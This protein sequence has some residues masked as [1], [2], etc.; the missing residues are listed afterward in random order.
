LPQAGTRITF[1]DDGV[2][3]QVSEAAHPRFE[4]HGNDLA[5]V[6]HCNLL[7]FLVTGSIHEIRTLDG[8]WLNVSIPPRTLRLRVPRE[9]MPYTRTDGSGGRAPDKG[10]LVVY[11]FAS[12]VTA[13][14]SAKT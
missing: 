2:C 11:L 1:E 6:V 9:G 8:R 10:D 4:R 14:Q 13:A 3:F 5:A 7:G 12:W